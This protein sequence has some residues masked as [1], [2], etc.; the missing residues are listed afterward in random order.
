MHLNLY[1]PFCSMAL[2]P[3][4]TDTVQN[5]RLP[6]GKVAEINRVCYESSWSNYG[7]SLEPY[8]IRV[9]EG[10]GWVKQESPLLLMHAI[11]LHNCYPFKVLQSF[12]CLDIIKTLSRPNLNHPKLGFRQYK[13]HDQSR[14]HDQRQW[15]SLPHA[16]DEDT[17]GC[18]LY[19]SPIHTRCHTSTRLFPHW[20]PDTSLIPGLTRAFSRENSCQER[21]MTPRRL[22]LQLSQ[23][24]PDCRYGNLN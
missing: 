1:T 22:R 11:G 3:N 4:S 12:F 16:C 14:S 17:G 21:S 7:S 19:D 13:D 5:C 10:R 2:P 8:Q 20:A 9:T 15:I 23:H 24:P 6:Q 18:T